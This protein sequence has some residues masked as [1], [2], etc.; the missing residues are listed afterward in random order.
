MQQFFA[1][2]G[3][4]A[5]KRAFNQSVEIIS[6]NIFFMEQLSTELIEEVLNLS[7]TNTDSS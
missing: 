1:N 4:G 6:A 5:G 3:V 7:T 2:H